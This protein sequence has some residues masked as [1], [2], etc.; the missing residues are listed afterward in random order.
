MKIWRDDIGRWPMTEPVAY[1]KLHAFTKK[2]KTSSTKSFKISI[3]I[4][5]VQSCGE[6]AV[7]WS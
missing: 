6:Q 3:R 5:A 2:L 7:Q 4:N 1:G